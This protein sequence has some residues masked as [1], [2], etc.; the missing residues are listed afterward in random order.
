MDI[1]L[2]YL[3]GNFGREEGLD[4]YSAALDTQL[5]DSICLVS[6]GNYKM[7]KNGIMSKRKVFK[8]NCRH[9]RWLLLHK[10]VEV[11]L[12]LLLCFFFSF[13]KGIVQRTSICFYFHKHFG[14]SCQTSPDNNLG[15][16]TPN[17]LSSSF[18]EQL[19][20]CCSPQ[21]HTY[22]SLQSISGL[23]SCRSDYGLSHELN[24]VS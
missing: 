7:I 17:F 6:Q 11:F 18:K 21:T 4:A 13:S 19:A 20:F 23:A 14:I 5:R 16:S 15:V 2:F 3:Q 10:D 1:F 8:I 22:P 12:F 9:Q 24:T